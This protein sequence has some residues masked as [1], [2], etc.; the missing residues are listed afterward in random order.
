MVGFD[1]PHVTNDMILRFMDV[2]VSLVAGQAASSKSRVGDD[3][4]VYLG[5]VSSLAGAGVPLLKGGK[6]DWECE[7]TLGLILLP[8]ADGTAWYNAGSAIL[9]LLILC[10]IVGLYF[11]FRRRGPIHAKRGI[12]GLPADRND[13]AERVPLGSERLELDDLEDRERRHRKGKSRMLDEEER[14]ETVFALGD[15]EDEDERER[16]R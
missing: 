4:R 8:G 2:D 1:V 10:S 3:E 13:D 9:I 15:E 14:G 11:Y 7:S 6:T 16:H 12:V 5:L